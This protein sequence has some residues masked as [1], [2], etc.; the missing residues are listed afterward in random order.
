MRWPS[1][2]ASKRSP[3][4]QASKK[5]GHPGARSQNP[6]AFTRFSWL[7]L[8]RLGRVVGEEE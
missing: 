5:M 6:Y 8:G 7:S 3:A 1:T 2:A 4:L